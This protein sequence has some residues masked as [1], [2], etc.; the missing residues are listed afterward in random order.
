MIT[1]DLKI[2]FKDQNM[3]YFSASANVSIKRKCSIYQFCSLD[4]TDLPFGENP[5][6]KNTIILLRPVSF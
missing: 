6:V 3:V 5:L 1:A 2:T 4:M